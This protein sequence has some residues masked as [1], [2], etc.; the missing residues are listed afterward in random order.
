L[1][2]THNLREAEMLCSEVAFLKNGRIA[3][4][5]TIPDLQA[6]LGLGDHL[7][8][9]YRNGIPPLDFHRLPGV[10]SCEVKDSQVHLVLDRVEV[11]LAPLLEEIT[12]QS[13]DPPEVRVKEADL[14]ELY[15]EITH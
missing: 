11:R 9:T 12:H 4:T 6:R 2:T 8:L 13:P 5:G 10:L 15:R 14:E 3:A 7:S 1:L